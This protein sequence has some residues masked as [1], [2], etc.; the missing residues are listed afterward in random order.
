MSQEW[1]QPVLVDSRPGANAIIG[2]EHVVKAA[3][4]GYTLL[5]SDPQLVNNAS[6]YAKLPYD[7]VRDLVSVGGLVRHNYLLVAAPN[8]KLAN[9]TDIIKAAKA[10]PQTLTYA[11]IGIGSGFHLAMELFQSMSGMPPLVH[12]P[13]KGSPA[14]LIDVTTGRVELMFVPIAS[15]FPNIKA[16][17]LRVI[18][19]T[20][21]NRIP[22]FPDLPTV[23]ES[24]VPGF[25][26]SSWF[27]LNAPRGTPAPVIRRVNDEVRKIVADPAFAAKYLEPYAYFPML[28]SPEDF[29]AFLAA[30]FQKWGKIARDANIRLD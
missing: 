2:T 1:G 29:S 10:R 21:T 3:P 26:V 16:G 6:V 4:D 27:G 18:A 5:T 12:V 24:G 19:M 9:V 14:A 28:G 7:G 8:S 11:S 22:Q 20:G 17:K 23:A 30:E 15:A 13:Y 25:E